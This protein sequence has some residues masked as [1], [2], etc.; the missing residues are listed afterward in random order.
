MLTSD[1][2]RLLE[3]V[4]A[5]SSLS[6][7]VEESQKRIQTMTNSYELE[8]NKL[9]GLLRSKQEEKDQIVAAYSKLI[10]NYESIKREFGSLK[11]DNLR[12]RE[13]LDKIKLQHIPSELKADFEKELE[14]LRNENVRLREAY[15]SIE[16]ERNKWRVNFA[17]DYKLLIAL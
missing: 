9:Q 1:N 14:L 8:I 16:I 12:L 4:K 5:T 6:N 13:K 17:E 15:S 11:G 3:Q 7:Q 10:K 2:E